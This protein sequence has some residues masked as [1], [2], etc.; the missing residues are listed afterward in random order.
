MVHLCTRVGIEMSMTQIRT[1][2]QPADD[3]EPARTHGDNRPLPVRSLRD[4]LD[5]LA[6]RDRLVVV[7]PGI[8]LPTSP[9]LPSVSTGCA[10]LCFRVPADIRF[11]SSPG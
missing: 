2:L 9:P 8:G 3:L 10:P 4:W 5:H 1:P 6:A 11:R 7:K